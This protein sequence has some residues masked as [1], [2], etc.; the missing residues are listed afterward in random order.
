MSPLSL[1][2]GFFFVILCMILQNLANAHVLKSGPDCLA[3]RLDENGYPRTGEHSTFVEPV[4]NKNYAHY[5]WKKSAIIQL[6]GKD[7][8]YVCV[9]DHPVCLTATNEAFLIRAQLENKKPGDHSQLWYID[10]KYGDSLRNFKY[11]YISSD[12]FP[13]EACS[14]LVGGNLDLISCGNEGNKVKITE[15]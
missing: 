3:F 9:K 5:F 14:F 1:H 6:E 8:F 4:K 10:P 2:S 15:K 13:Y 12:Y 11:S 7:V